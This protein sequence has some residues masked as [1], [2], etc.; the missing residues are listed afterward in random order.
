MCYCRYVAVGNEPFLTSYGDKYVKK[1]FPAMQNIQKAIDKAGHGEVKVT[2]A[3]NADVYESQTNKP[4]D[5]DFRDNIRDVMK[6]IIQ[7]LHEKK[8][9]FLVNIYPF[10]SLYQSEGFPEDFAF[11]GTHSMTISDK[12][13]QYSNVFDANLDTL[14]WALKKSGYSDIK[15]VV[16]EIGWPTDGNKNANVNNAKRFYQGFLKNMA[17]KKGTPMLPGHMDAYLFSLFDENL[18]SIDPGNFERHWGIYRYDG[19]PKFPIDFSGKGEEKLPQSAKGVRYQEHKWCVLNADVKN[20][21]LIP[22]ALD[23]ACAGADC[24]SLGYGCSCGNLGLAGNASFAFNQFFQTRD[25]SVEACDF[26]G[27]GSIVTQDPSKGTCLFPIELE[28]NN[29]DMLTT[30]R[31]MASMLIGLSIFF[32]TL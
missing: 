1:T 25:Q 8:S 7:F 29:G 5:G 23:Y 15:I 28:S 9:P 17:S 13:A 21:S 10:L 30:M 11:F 27:L 31:I 12:N 16:G 19:K 22:P 18:K 3:L 6:Q 26:N 14:A 4:S 2:T 20:M 32:I 24:T